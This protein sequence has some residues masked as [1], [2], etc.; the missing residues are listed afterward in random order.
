MNRT[1]A[2]GGGEGVLIC[3]K[4]QDS[5]LQ[6]IQEAEAFPQ[7]PS[8]EAVQTTEVN[9]DCTGRCGFSRWGVI[10]PTTKA[11]KEPH[12]KAIL[13]QDCEQTRPRPPWKILLLTLAISGSWFLGR[14]HS[15]EMLWTHTQSRAPLHTVPW[16]T[17]HLYT[18]GRCPEHRRPGN[19]HLPEVFT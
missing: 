9:C 15:R 5:L 13:K 1:T 6:T 7:G 14:E 3:L 17:T 8:W 18:H 4:V 2:N 12:G 10:Y 19:S 16:H 11:S